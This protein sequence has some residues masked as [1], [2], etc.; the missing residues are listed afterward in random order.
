MESDGSKSA[1]RVRREPPQFRKVAVERVIRLGPWMMRVTLA[2]SEL[3]GLHV[4]SPA[5]SVR[6]LLPSPGDTELVIPVWNGNEFLLPDGRRPVIRTFTPRRVDAESMQLD[7][8]VVIHEHGIAS[9]WT[10]SARPGDPAAVSGPGRGYAVD[11]NASRFLIGGD[12]SA[13]PAIGQLLEAIPQQTPVEVHI[14]IAHPDARLP[15]P[16]HGDAVRWHDLPPGSPPGAR[17]VA[18]MIECEISADTRIWVAGEA[19]S[20]QK[21]RR[22]LFLER[23]IPREQ[24]TVRGYWKHT[25]P[26]GG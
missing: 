21:I 8:D 15:M 22:H 20:V 6:L 18:A 19:A 13:I 26:G 10:R 5:A 12:E 1:E 24:V 25:K 7:L 9:H 2:G 11:R 16:D 3:A 14:E 4:D 23:G 17:L